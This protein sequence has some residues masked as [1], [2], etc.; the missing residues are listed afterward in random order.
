MVQHSCSSNILQQGT[1]RVGMSGASHSGTE[2]HPPSTTSTGRGHEQPTISNGILITFLPP[3]SRRRHTSPLFGEVLES[4]LG[5]VFLGA[6]PSEGHAPDV[7]LLPAPLL[8]LRRRHLQF[9]VEL[10]PALGP[11]LVGV[12][13][14]R[15]LPYLA[16]LRLEGLQLSSPLRHDHADR[17]AR[18]EDHGEVGAGQLPVHGEGGFQPIRLHDPLKRGHPVFRPVRRT[19]GLEIVAWRGPEEERQVPGEYAAS[20]VA[21][22]EVNFLTV[23]RFNLDIRGVVA[24]VPGHTK[25]MAVQD[26]P[27]GLGRYSQRQATVGEPHRGGV[28]PVAIGGR[29][30]EAHRGP[31]TGAVSDQF[32]VLTFVAS[33]LRILY[34]A[35]RHCPLLSPRSERFPSRPRCCGSVAWRR[36]H[37]LSGRPPCGTPSSRRT[38][39]VPAAAWPRRTRIK[40]LPEGSVTLL[41]PCCLSLGSCGK[42]LPL[43]KPLRLVAPGPAR[44]P[45][46][47]QRLA[48]TLSDPARR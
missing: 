27:P 12:F 14:F 5:L 24:A 44:A 19:A 31:R 1:G 21:A 11:P 15:L 41:L 47:R 13:K 37:H 38:F 18:L 28:H 39:R 16:D 9:S 33:S 35:F 32:G 4:E 8:S 3:V 20:E 42:R 22:C 29:Y 36:P 6:D 26:E 30:D 10:P 23:Q 46:G 48:R 43:F 2:S 45:P 34:G 25:R 40:R 7:I 17:L